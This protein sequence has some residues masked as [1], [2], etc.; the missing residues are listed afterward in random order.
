VTDN[1]FTNPVAGLAMANPLL[2]SIFAPQLVGETLKRMG[3]MTVG[4]VTIILG[5]TILIAGTSAGKQATAAAI[6]TGK[7]VAKVAAVIPK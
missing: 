6:K 2:G 5:T 7:T 3:I 4:L 1:P